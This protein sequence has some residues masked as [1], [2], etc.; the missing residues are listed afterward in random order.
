QIE[1]TFQPN[2]AKTFKSK[3]VL[4]YDTGETTKIYVVGKGYEEKLCLEHDKIQMSDTYVTSSRQTPIKI[5]NKSNATGKF[6]WSIF[7]TNEMEENYINSKKNELIIIDSMDRF[8][9]KLSKSNNLI[10]KVKLNEHAD[11]DRIP[12]MLPVLNKDD[13]NCLLHAISIS[14]WGVN[15]VQLTLR[16]SLY[17]YMKNIAPSLYRRWKFD[18]LHNY[19]S[20]DF[21][22]SESEWKLEWDN[23]VNLSKCEPKS[24]ESYPVY[25]SLEPIH[26][27]ILSNM[28]K[29]CIIVYSQEMVKDASGNDISKNSFR[30]IYSPYL[31]PNTECYRNPIYL[32]YHNSHFEPIIALY[33]N[34]SI[35]ETYTPIK[36]IKESDLKFSVDPGCDAIWDI[37]TSFRYVSQQDHVNVSDY[38]TVK[39][40]NIKNNKLI[41]EDNE[42]HEKDTPNIYSVEGLA[43]QSTESMYYFKAQRILEKIKRI[44]NNVNKL[45]I[46]KGESSKLNDMS[47]YSLSDDIDFIHNPILFTK[48]DN[49]CENDMNLQCF[50][51]KCIVNYDRLN[52]I[53][54]FIMSSFGEN[55]WT[56]IISDIGIAFD[57]FEH[58]RKYCESLLINIINAMTKITK[59][60]RDILMEKCGKNFHCFLVNNGFKDTIEVIGRDLSGFIMCLDDVHN[61]M[62]PY[63]PNMQNPTFIVRNQ[64][65]NGITIIYTSHRQGF[66]NYVIGI[67]KSIANKMFNVYPTF[68]IISSVINSDNYKYVIELKYNNEN[69]IT[70]LVNFDY[71]CTFSTE[72]SDLEFEGMMQY[73][74]ES[75]QLMFT[76]I[77]VYYIILFLIKNSCKTA[78]QLIESKLFLADLGKCDLTRN[79]IFSVMNHEAES[80]YSLHMASEFI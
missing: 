76:G 58:D 60:D 52:G 12:Y 70:N 18:E 78:H 73:L 32:F 68:T 38:L 2:S 23:V 36:T 8:F 6:I 11:D 40:V 45:H 29:R 64:N 77:P 59:L 19:R 4:R 71:H 62:T 47:E 17:Q 43:S 80:I 65:Q 14:L 46:F 15:D 39:L 61:F 34:V 66:A 37:T 21:I 49:L 53:R 41:V 24:K 3:I 63:F 16:K 44:Y 22:L 74:P 31:H 5:I 13:G 33:K 56:E 48:F 54:N 57:N 26:V 50:V 51:V 35:K 55:V 67:L 75:E 42:N 69:Y 9:K 30:G 1:F 27:F 10:L 72:S 20:I 7:E 25:Y 79:I 28:L